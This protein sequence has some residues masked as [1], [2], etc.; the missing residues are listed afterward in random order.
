MPRGAFIN[1][2]NGKSHSIN[3]IT[4]LTGSGGSFHPP[5]SESYHSSVRPHYGTPAP[6]QTGHRSHLDQ[7]F[8]MSN[9]MPQELHSQGNYIR[10]IFDT[11]SISCASS[12]A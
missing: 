5:V 6:F 12:L 9:Q 2:C 8:G 11:V 3:I 7:R 1:T 4:M 10:I